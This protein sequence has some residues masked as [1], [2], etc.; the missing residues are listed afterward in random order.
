MLITTAANYNSLKVF[1]YDGTMSSIKKPI[2]KIGSF[3]VLDVG[4]VPI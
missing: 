4:T 1:V 3:K 2:G